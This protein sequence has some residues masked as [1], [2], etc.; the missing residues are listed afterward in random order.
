MLEPDSRWL[1]LVEEAGRWGVRLSATGG[2]ERDELGLWI[3][4]DE[5]EARRRL[6]YLL[7]VCPAPDGWRLTVENTKSG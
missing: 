6:D 3:S 7:E 1:Q 5:G 2:V 4:R